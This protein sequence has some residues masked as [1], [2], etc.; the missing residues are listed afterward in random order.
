[1]FTWRRLL[2]HCEAA[3]E[4]GDEADKAARLEWARLYSLS[5]VFDGHEE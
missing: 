4:Q 3:V 5:P 1:M 2:G